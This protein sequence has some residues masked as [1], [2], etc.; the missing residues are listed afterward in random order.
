M[1]KNSLRLGNISG[2]PIFVHWSFAAIIAYVIYI[3]VSNDFG[4]W[5]TTWYML[6]ILS[7]FGCVLLHELGHSLSARWYGIETEDITLLPIG[8]LA[9]LERMPKKPIQELVIAI[10]GPAV[11]VVIAIVLAGLHW[12][13]FGDFFNNISL[14]GDFT[15]NSYIALLTTINIILVVFNMIPAFPM[16]GG[17]VFRALL[18]FK[19]SHVVATKIASIVGKLAAVCFIGYGFSQNDYTLMGV[20]AFVFYAAS[21]ENKIASMEGALEGQTVQ[22]MIRDR[23]TIFQTTDTVASV[24]NALSTGL[25]TDFLVLNNNLV[26]GI[27]TKAIIVKHNAQNPDITLNQVMKTDI[28]ATN[29]QESLTEVWMLIRGHKQ[30]I[31]PVFDSTT[32]LL[33]GVLDQRTIYNFIEMKNSRWHN[34][35]VSLQ[36]SIVMPA[37]YG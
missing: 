9:R 35:V 13:L 17:R 14:S 34:I 19:F 24:M 36:L 26:E 32:G 28:F 5:G 12:L 31:V 33:L 20:G 1:N 8:G 16:D 27:V 15:L 37:F 2:I 29:P 30:P 22:L 21:M 18:S 3:G 6:L 10:M 23:Y 7:V 25:E 11:N 4:I